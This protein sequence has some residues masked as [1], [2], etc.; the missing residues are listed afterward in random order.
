[1]FVLLEST[2]LGLMENFWDGYLRDPGA[3][4]H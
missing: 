2:S 4:E 1:M 3:R